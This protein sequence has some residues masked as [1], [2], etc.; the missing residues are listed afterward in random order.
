MGARLKPKTQ[1]KSAI[2]AKTEI[3]KQ[4]FTFHKM[5]TN[6]VKHSDTGDYTGLQELLTESLHDLRK[7]HA[8]L[9]LPHIQKKLDAGLHNTEDLPNKELSTLSSQI[10]DVLYAT[11]HLLQPSNLVLADHFLGTYLN[12]K[13]DPLRYQFLIKQYSRIRRLAV[14]PCSCPAKCP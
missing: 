11:D 2:E 7:I 5:T 12:H 9:T 6:G 10:V 13:T 3:H 8:R 1:V 14:S 4:K